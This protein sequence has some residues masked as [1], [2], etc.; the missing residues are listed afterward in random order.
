MK[1]KLF[2]LI[3]LISISQ[4]HSMS[5]PLS[6][7]QADGERPSMVSPRNTCPSPKSLSKLRKV[8]KKIESNPE[9]S[10]ELGKLL[11]QLERLQS[12]SK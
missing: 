12:H 3:G 9:R 7:R 2:L 4:L 10:G 1:N 5:T 8:I 6:E 11:I